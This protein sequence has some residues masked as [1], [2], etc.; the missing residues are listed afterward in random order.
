M[1]ANPGGNASNFFDAS[2]AWLNG[3]RGPALRNGMLDTPADLTVTTSDAT[4]FVAR[5]VTW[6]ITKEADHDGR[7][8]VAPGD[9]ATFTYTL[10]VTH[11]T[12]PE[13]VFDA[14]NNEWAVP[15]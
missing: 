8:A 13:D 1:P 14:I 3:G 12:G 15:V 5:A 11:E 9:A 4:P 7:L 10:T 2:L 6:H